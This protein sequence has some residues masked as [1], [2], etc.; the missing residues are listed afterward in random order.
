MPKPIEIRDF[1]RK[2]RKA[3]DNFFEDY[4]FRALNDRENVLLIRREIDWVDD[5]FDF[6]IDELKIPE[7]SAP[8]LVAEKDQAEFALFV[9]D[10]QEKIK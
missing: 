9:H 10:P 4:K 1:E 5:L 7:I 6:L 8:V 3:F 2:A